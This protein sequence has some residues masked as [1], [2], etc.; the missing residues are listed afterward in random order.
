VNRLVLSNTAAQI[1]TPAG[2][3]SRISAVREQG[4]DAIVDGSIERWFTPSFI[5]REPATIEAIRRVLRTTSAEG[6]ASC[7]EAVRDMDLR[8]SAPRIRAPTLVIAGDADQSTTPADAEWLASHIPGGR[9][10]VLSAAHLAN[11]E[12]RDAFNAELTAFLS[13]AEA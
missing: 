7:C 3:N 2:W 12:A 4:I 13:G 8:E 6:Y 1:G 10:V 11:I 5:A 9:A